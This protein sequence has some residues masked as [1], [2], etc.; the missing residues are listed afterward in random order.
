MG[1]GVHVLA[2]ISVC[3]V[4]LELSI[5]DMYYLCVWKK[6]MAHKCKHFSFQWE[7]EPFLDSSLKTDGIS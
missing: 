2:G 1:D 5:T 7:D 6:K 3:H 4:C